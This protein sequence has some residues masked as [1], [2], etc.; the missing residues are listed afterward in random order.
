MS[1]ALQQLREHGQSPWIDFITRDFVRGGELAGLIDDGIAGLTSNPTI[2]EQ[3]IAEGESYDEQL[4]EVLETETRPQ[5]G[6]PRRSPART[7]AAPATTCAAVYDAAR[8]IR[9]GWVSLEVDPDLADDSEATA[10]E[11]KR[12]ARDGRAAEPVREDP[13]HGGRTQRRSRRRSP[14]GSRST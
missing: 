10:R 1:N 14:R 11:A 8:P 5:G 3:A 9:D 13:R 4:R 6:V 12:A 2:F 7:S